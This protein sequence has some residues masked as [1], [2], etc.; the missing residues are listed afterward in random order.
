[1]LLIH[2]KAINPYLAMHI[3][4]VHVSFIC[5]FVVLFCF[6]D[7]FQKHDMLVFLAINNI[8]FIKKL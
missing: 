5:N 3:C 4:N 2:I 8:N 7:S 1:M 6:D